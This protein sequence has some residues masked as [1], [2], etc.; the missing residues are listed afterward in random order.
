MIGFPYGCLIT[1]LILA[2]SVQQIGDFDTVWLV[3]NFG[4][5]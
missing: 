3:S 4:N 1:Q 5:Q 2:T